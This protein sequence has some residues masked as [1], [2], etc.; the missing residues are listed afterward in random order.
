V[1]TLQFSATYAPSESGNAGGDWFE[2]LRL[3]A[4]LAFVAIGEAFGHGAAAAATMHE[5]RRALCVAAYD[6]AMTP[7][8]M[9]EQASQTLQA[10]D[11]QALASAFVGVIDERS[12]RLH[13]A[14]AGHPPAVLVGTHGTRMLHATGSL[15]GYGSTAIENRITY[16]ER[17]AMLVLYTDGLTEFNRNVVEGQRLLL[18]SSIA[19]AHDPSPTPAASI[20]SSTLG[21]AKSQDDIVVLTVRVIATLRDPRAHDLPPLVA[22]RLTW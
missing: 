11:S 20:I 22:E 17:G 7:S 15:L 14:S 9:L 19:E 18:N 1:Y 21:E 4:N 8:L 12:G 2:I 3:P 16:L 6:D 5:V 13:Y 10:F